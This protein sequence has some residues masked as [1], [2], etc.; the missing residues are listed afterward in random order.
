MST[1]KKG[2]LLLMAALALAAPAMAAQPVPSAAM[3]NRSLA[4]NIP[5]ADAPLAMLYNQYDNSGGVIVNSQNFEAAY[6]AYDDFAADDFVV[7]ANTSWKSTGIG[8]QG[9]YFN[10][11]GPAASFNVLIYTGED[12]PGV[13]RVTKSNLTYTLN[14]TDQFRIKVSPAITVPASP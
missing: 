12:E 4:P 2:A 1:M 9:G 8:V 6:D 3:P 13:L 14:G 11:P 7:P 5:W 10:G